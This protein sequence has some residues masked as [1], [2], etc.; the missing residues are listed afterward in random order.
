MIIAKQRFGTD[1]TYL[2]P[3][4]YFRIRIQYN[5]PLT[6]RMGTLSSRCHP[7]PQDF[8]GCQSPDNARPGLNSDTYFTL[9]RTYT[10]KIVSTVGVV[11]SHWFEARWQG[12]NSWDQMPYIQI[13]TYVL[14]RS[15]KKILSFH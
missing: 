7:F 5:R 3:G 13:S 12:T 8:G 4:T 2:V 10:S 11:A 15:Q 1:G 9:C 14:R 6:F